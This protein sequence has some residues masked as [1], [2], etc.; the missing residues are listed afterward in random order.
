VTTSRADYGIYRPVLREISARPELDLRLLITGS[1]LSPQFGLTVSEIEADGYDTSARIEM[2][3]SSDTPEA[4]VAATGQAIIGFAGYYSHTRPGLLLVLGD[5]FEMHAAVT[6]AVPFLIPVAHIHGGELTEGAIDDT[7]RHSMTKM[8]HLHF[9]A[10]EVYA[11]RIRQM[12]EESW[13]V[14]VSGAPS[15]DNLNDFKPANDAEL[16]QRFGLSLDQPFLLSTY[17]P[18]TLENENGAAKIEQLL[19]AMSRLNMPVLFTYPNADAGSNQ[20]IEQVQEYVAQPGRGWLLPSLGSRAYFTLMGRAA[21]MV[22]NSSSGI[23]EAASFRLPVVNIGN[24]QAGRLRAVNVIDV[25][26]SQADIEAG[27][28]RGLDP[29]FRNSLANLRN[30]YGDGHAA[31]RIVDKIQ[32]IELNQRLL[33]KRFQ[34]Q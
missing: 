6:A 24:R 20:I 23:I 12:G 27:L 14:I 28:N 31:K 2:T 26:E 21:A 16:S 5:R 34:E 13:R 19:R 22:G 3:S 10:T 18:V 7:L 8:S 4:I 15:L 33:K 29:A 9:A 11:N 1:H 17:H 30:P 32:S 25:G